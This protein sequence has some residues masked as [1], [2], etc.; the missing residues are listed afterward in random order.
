MSD[1]KKEEPQPT[2]NKKAYRRPE[3]QRLGSLRE[4]T[5]GN[6]FGGPDGRPHRG[7]GRGGDYC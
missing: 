5:L 1:R 4:I 3:L 2:A 6:F 7:T